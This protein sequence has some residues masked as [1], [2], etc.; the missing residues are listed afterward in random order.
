[1]EYKTENAPNVFTC[2]RLGALE[3]GR[4]LPKTLNAENE[5]KENRCCCQEKNKKN[6]RLRREKTLFKI[7]FSAKRCFQCFFSNDKDDA[8]AKEKNKK[9]TRL[10]RE[11]TLFKNCFLCE[12]VFSMF[13]SNDKDE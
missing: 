5:N 8:A 1:M 6:T 7:V 3:N 10:R 11:K 9:N 2:P 4:N 13:F 12:A